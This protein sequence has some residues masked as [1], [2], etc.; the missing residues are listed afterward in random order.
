MNEPKISFSDEQALIL[1]TA[2]TFARENTSA[3]SIRALIASESGYDAAVW[4]RIVDLGWSGLV[5]PEAHGGSGLSI[6]DAVPIV[7]PPGR[8]L[9]APPLL[10]TL[11]A[12]AA[13]APAAATHE[14]AARWSAKLATGAVGSVA[15]H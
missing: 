7:E 12:A 6:A 4:Q 5:V 13:I 10:P 1:E 8:Y 15:L 9:L 14:A 11:L 3:A 2:L